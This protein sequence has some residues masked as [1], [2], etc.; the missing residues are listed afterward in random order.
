MMNLM[1]G[2]LRMELAQRRVSNTSNDVSDS[3]IPSYTISQFLS[4]SEN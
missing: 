3:E 2:D 1:A 4:Q